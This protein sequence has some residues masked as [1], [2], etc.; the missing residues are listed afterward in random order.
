MKVK[1]GMCTDRDRT[2]EE[3]SDSVKNKLAGRS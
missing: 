2:I 1:F 3:R